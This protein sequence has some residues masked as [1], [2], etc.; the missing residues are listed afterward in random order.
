MADFLTVLQIQDQS[1][2]VKIPYSYEGMVMLACRS[3]QWPQFTLIMSL[4]VL[5]PN[6][7]TSQS[8]GVWGLAGIYSEKTELYHTLHIL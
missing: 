5:S 3:P 8:P 2:S 7:T 4:K 1:V 6:I